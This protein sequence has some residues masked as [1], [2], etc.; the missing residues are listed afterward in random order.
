MESR[1]EDT[2]GPISG[3][4]PDDPG[5]PQIDAP[6]SIRAGLQDQSRFNVRSLEVHASLGPSSGANS[7]PRIIESFCTKIEGML[8]KHQQELLAKI[9]HAGYPKSAMAKSASWDSFAL[10]SHN[11][12]QELQSAGREYESANSLNS[13]GS[14]TRGHAGRPSARFSTKPADLIEVGTL[15]STATTNGPENRR[16]SATET[17]NHRNSTDTGGPSVEA[18][19]TIGLVW[20]LEEDDQKRKEEATAVDAKSEEPIYEDDELAEQLEII[21]VGWKRAILKCV[22]SS[23]FELTMAV[24]I[25]TNSVFIGVQ[26]DWAARNPNEAAPIAFYVL[27]QLYAAIF[28]VELILRLLAEG[29]YFCWS[30]QW[31]WNFLDVFLVVASLFEVVTE[32]LAALD[33]SNSSM[34]NM[35]NVR[36]I[37][38]VRIARVMRIFRILRVVR[39]IRGLRT[40]LFSIMCTLKSLVWAMLLLIIIMYVFGIIF[41]QAISDHLVEADEN[42]AQEDESPHNQL[43]R[44]HYGSL[45]TSMYTLFESVAGGLSWGAMTQPLNTVGIMCNVVFT[46]YVAFVYFAVLNVVT[47][48]FCHAAIESAQHDQ[49]MVIQQ[50]LANRQRYIQKVKQLFEDLDTDSSGTITLNEFESHFQDESVQAYFHSLDLDPKDAWTLFKLLDS[51]CTHQ[52]DIEEFAI[53]CLRLRGPAKRIDI[54]KLMY[55]HQR[56]L[57]GLSAFSSLVEHK[58]QI[59]SGDTHR[60]TNTSVQPRPT[61]SM[62]N[63]QTFFEELKEVAK[64]GG[65]SRLDPL[66]DMPSLKRL[67]KQKS[68]TRR[69]SSSSTS[70]NSTESDTF[71]AS[72]TMDSKRSSLPTSVLGSAK[73]F[74]AS[75]QAK[76]YAKLFGAA[77]S[78]STSSPKGS[79]R[80]P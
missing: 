42:A 80:S 46:V 63:A 56:M 68:K 20:D 45:T 79:P 73:S 17:Y 22:A 28:L 61:P 23:E 58:L 14:A 62:A 12:S 67:K 35:S 36:I 78:H 25:I 7:V 34:Q 40:L 69:F 55:D 8:H 70:R 41:T 74:T 57:R 44:Q 59:I 5:A 29:T 50:E 15:N 26:V 3:K 31:H 71:T 52:V 60:L 47:G 65:A 24:C 43:L 10:G 64:S 53:G 33:S 4:L 6:D 39:F 11:F 38:V 49:D 21:K 48:V 66:Q 72:H 13:S 54:E 18:H 27:Q 75:S 77:G 1:L 76:I 2:D 30:S 16:V 37:R 51:H 19:T 9:A 32:L